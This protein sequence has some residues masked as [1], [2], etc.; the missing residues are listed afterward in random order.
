MSDDS[1]PQAVT[2]DLGASA[3]LDFD[4]VEA[5]EQAVETRLVSTERGDGEEPFGVELSL[6]FGALRTEI[7]LDGDATAALT[8]QL[9]TH[10]DALSE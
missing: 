4:A 3:T 9:T 6:D 8:E 5:T 2:T 1:E 10:R 7:V